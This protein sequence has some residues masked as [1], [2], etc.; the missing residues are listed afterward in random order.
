MVSNIRAVIFDAD[1]TLVD[2]F[3]LILNAYQHLAEQFGYPPPTEDAI[4]AQLNGQPV[5]AICRAL[6]PGANVDAM[7]AANSRY[8]EANRTSSAVFDG[9]IDMLEALRSAGLKLGIVTGGNRAYIQDT[10]KHHHIDRYFGAVVHSDEVANHKPHPE[11][12]LLAARRLHVRPD[13]CCMVG[14]AA[15]DILIGKNGGAAVTIGITHGHGSRGDLEAAHPD[16]IVDSLP[17]LMA[18][19]QKLLT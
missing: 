14:D 6:F 15:N 8:V 13:G 11:G 17:E 19:L 5:P 18:C 4:R 7:V 12:F 3:A 10:L 9:L 2:S 1:G 16:H